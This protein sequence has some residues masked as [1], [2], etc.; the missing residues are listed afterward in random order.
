[1]QSNPQSNPV[2][3]NDFKSRCNPPKRNAIRILQSCNHNPTDAWYAL[4]AVSSGARRAASRRAAL[5][6][7]EPALYGPTAD[8]ITHIHTLYVTQSRITVSLTA[9]AAAAA[10]DDS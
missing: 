9:T 5:C 10:A 6:V 4:C 7:S 2:F 1:M 8:M 3:W